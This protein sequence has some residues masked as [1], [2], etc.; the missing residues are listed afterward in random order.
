MKRVLIFSLALFT[1]LGAAAQ[2]YP[3]R[4][5]VR[6]GNR[7]YEKEK[8]VEAEITYRRALEK[9]AASYEAA[10]NLAKSLYKQQRWDEAAQAFSPLA[11]DSLNRAHAPA[12]NFDL[13][14]ALFKQRK[15]AEA[16]EA[17][18]SSLRL[19]PTDQQAKFNLAYAQKML[20]DQQGGGG[21]NDKDKDKNDQQ[22]QQQQ[23]QPQQGDG[24]PQPAE[25]RQGQ[26][27][28]QEAEQM[29]QA[30]QVGED[31]TREK[32]EKEKGKP[33]NARGGKNW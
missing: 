1:T 3:E 26:M 11:A 27:S 9:N 19:D 16:V 20:K 6:S 14:N 23:P 5:V 31:K 4:R 18:K 22:Q 8:Y 25:P 13:G 7:S 24:K 30:V 29:L 17:Y 28:Q 33:V 12:A 2:K 15:F 32:V 21:G 10:D